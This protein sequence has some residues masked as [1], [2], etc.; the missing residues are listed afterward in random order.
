MHVMQ[1]KKNNKYS[2]FIQLQKLIFV[3]RGRTLI[4]G[5]A[6]LLPAR[7]NRKNPDSLF[8]IGLTRFC[9]APTAII[10]EQ[11]THTRWGVSAQDLGPFYYGRSL[12]QHSANPKKLILLAVI[13]VVS[14]LWIRVILKILQVFPAMVLSISVLVLIP[15]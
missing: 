4:R 10:H 14:T 1:K 12:C 2:D 6:R 3:G 5:T 7:G 13:L 11:H 15:K 9:F 8:M